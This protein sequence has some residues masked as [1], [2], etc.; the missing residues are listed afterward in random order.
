M[1]ADLF[2]GVFAGF[3]FIVDLGMGRMDQPPSRLTSPPAEKL[4]R[5]LRGGAIVLPA[6]PKVKAA[7]PRKRSAISDLIP[8]SEIH[9]E[10]TY[11]GLLPPCR[12]R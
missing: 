7:T 3:M 10:R 5:P 11:M 6:S 8:L 12:Y 9:V 2:K 1:C 4:L